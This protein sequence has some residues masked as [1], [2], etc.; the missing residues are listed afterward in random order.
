M[1]EPLARWLASLTHRHK[2]SV[3][4]TALNSRWLQV[5]QFVVIQL[6]FRNFTAKVVNPFMYLIALNTHQTTRSQAYLPLSF[7]GRSLADSA[8]RPLVKALIL[9]F[10]PHFVPFAL[11]EVVHQHVL[12]HEA[13]VRGATKHHH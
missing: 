12:L 3:D 2:L 9:P 1:P 10:W 7:H 4:N 11:V 8:G 6:A 5:V 13:I